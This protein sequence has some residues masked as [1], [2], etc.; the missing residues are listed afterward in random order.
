MDR[1]AFVAASCGVL[2]VLAGCSGASGPDQKARIDA[3][4]LE[5]HH[6]DAGYEF[7]ARIDEGGERVFEATRSLGPAG[8]GEEVAVFEEPVD[9]SGTY[10]MRVEADGDV[11]TVDTRDYVEGDAACL[12]LGFYLDAATLHWEH[13]TYD[14]C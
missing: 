5:N 10:S 7:T 3:L 8:S 12:R 14:Q 4:E 1:R 9:G 6:R 2:G 11:A 13:V